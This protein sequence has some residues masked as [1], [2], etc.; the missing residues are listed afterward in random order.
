MS[1]ANPPPPEAEGAAQLDP[2]QVQYL[3]QQLESEQNLVLGVAGGLGASILGAA[4]WAGI[5][6]VSGYQIG[7]MAIGV[8]FLVGFV[9]RRLG[10]GVTNTFGI[11][12]AA[13]SLF[14]CAL[15]NLLAVT[16]LVAAEQGVAFGA[17]LAQLNLELIQQL[18]VAFF[19]PMDLLFYAIAVYYGYKLSFR[20]ITEADLQRMLSG[21]AAG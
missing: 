15:G 10:R 12:G 6:V 17:A 16:A 8:G 7:I 19:S 1:D 3:Q 18:M 13:L 11:A 5:T 4:V 9:V 20:Q 21:G 2:A 14:G